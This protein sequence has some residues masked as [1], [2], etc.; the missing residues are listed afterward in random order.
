MDDY[1]KLFQFDE[2]FDVKLF[3]EITVAS[4]SHKHPQF[5]QA[6]KVLVEFRENPQS[7]TRVPVILELAQHPHTKRFALT[8]LESLV[9]HRWN[10][11][12]DEQRCGIREFMINYVLR[13]S[14]TR[15]S[16]SSERLII[17]AANAVLVSI[18]CQEWPHRW[19][20]F[21]PEIVA[22]SKINEST[23]ENNLVIL[24]MLSEDIFDFNKGKMTR[25]KTS[26]LKEGLVKDFFP[27]YELCEFVLS[28]SKTPSLLQ[29]TLDALLKFLSWVP[30][31]YIFET[32]MISILIDN[33]L[34]EPQF[35]NAATSCLVE[36]SS[37]SSQDVP[38][39]KFQMMFS[40]FMNQLYRI[41]DKSTNFP[42][43]YAQSS[44]EDKSFI[45]MVALFL[46]T[47]FQRHLSVLESDALSYYILD[48]H[49]YLVQFCS[50][51]NRDI[52]GIIL[53]YWMVLSEGL[54]KE[55]PIDQ[56]A[57]AVQTSRRVFYANVLSQVRSIMI[58]NM[59]KPEE[60]LVVEDENGNIIRERLKNTEQL[61]LYNNMRITLVYLSNLDSTDM[62]NIMLQRLHELNGE[63]FDKRACATLCWAI[64]SISGAVPEERERRFLVHVVR[65]LIE[66]CNEMRSKDDRAII[67]ANIMYVV[68]QYPQ[69]LKAHW[70][71]LRTVVHKLFE[72]MEETHPGVQDMACDT[73][74]K[75][76]RSTA[77]QFVISQGKGEG[78]FIDV[79]L[80]NIE[81]FISKLDEGQLLTFYS[82][83]SVLI[84]ANS[85]PVKKQQQI[86]LMM[87][88]PNST[89]H[90]ITACA[91][92]DINIL[93]DLEVVRNIA[94]IVKTNISACKVLGQSFESQIYRIYY[95]MLNIYKVYSE[96]IS[97]SVQQQGPRYLNTTDAKARRTVKQ[98]ILVLIRTYVKRTTNPNSIVSS[99]LQ[100]L[101]KSVLEDYKFGIPEARDPEVL[102]L[103]SELIRKCQDL[104]I[105]EIPL[106]FDSVFECTIS[107]IT[108]NFADYPDHRIQF[109]DFICSVNHSCFKALLLMPSSHFQTI[110]NAIVWAL[111]HTM[112]NVSKTGLQT[113]LELLLNVEK[114]GVANEFYS[115]CFL[116]L[117]QEI[118]VMLLDGLHKAD[119][120]MHCKILQKMFSAI[121]NN[122]VTV[123]LWNDGDSAHPST[124]NVQFLHA[125]ISKTLINAFPNL[126]QTVTGNFV[127]GLF[128]S[129][130]SLSTL[131]NHIRDFLIQIKEYNDVE[132]NQL[133]YDE[134]LNAEKKKLQEELIS[135]QMRIPGMIPPNDPRR[136]ENINAQSSNAGEPAVD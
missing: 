64:G 80:E 22:A 41:L 77:K 110:I 103:L 126:T 95:D 58:R 29:T 115:V 35:R 19:S 71:F 47:L 72:W 7:W 21:I 117:L 99:I 88:L 43:V 45:Q 130:G 59:A 52:F 136:P 114:E 20:S 24:K 131:K 118:L 54:Y 13:L 55:V 132:D 84:N 2:E 4:I 127:S 82:A 124:N 70:T 3:E 81:K 36:I 15:E 28:S 63:N 12:P 32:Q 68:G 125:H 49:M 61:Y 31:G 96:D 74:L 23:C 11:L 18:S 129:T 87:K 92:S 66:F 76:S 38:A 42:L 108:E 93:R 121:Q 44:A 65:K 109:F 133:L 94:K 89:W 67:A 101:L 51:K 128:E 50:I 5:A 69:F 17:D 10:L 73:F 102:T 75:I 86:E 122:V 79:L 37:I 112:R 106:F 105:D 9:T 25:A 83:V 119:F 46:T 8:I 97:A 56:S 27:I 33:F 6:A 100:P 123:P 91:S 40:S 78:P 104:I 107:M 113:L 85:N 26:L 39:E 1:S 90:Q 30:I 120:Y 62:Y 14:S 53:D 60:V 34:P 111:R 116:S 135:L 48:A 134:E 98:N 57:P 16:L